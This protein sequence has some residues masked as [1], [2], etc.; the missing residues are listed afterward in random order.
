VEVQACSIDAPYAI[1]VY[2]GVFG[3]LQCGK[4]VLALVELKNSEMS[5]WR[6][7]DAKGR[8]H[9]RVQQ[10]AAFTLHGKSEGTLLSVQE[11]C[12]E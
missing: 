10:Q 3:P 7:K 11:C 8:M 1:W 6:S 4:G 5:V 9:T 12:L 2:D